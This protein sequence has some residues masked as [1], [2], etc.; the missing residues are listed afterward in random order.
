MRLSLIVAMAENRIIGRDGA[1]PWHISADLR[2]FK[3]VT[4]GAP[5]IMGRK[6]FQSIGRALPG[7]TNII[8]TRDH[9]FTGD[10]IEV[11]HDLQAALRKAAALCLVEGR[12]E[13]FVIGGAQIYELALE[14]AERIYL[15]E[16]HTSPP[17][18]TRFPLLDPDIWKETSREDHGPESEGGPAFSFLI[19]DKLR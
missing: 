19:L 15:T 17:G 13:V 6:T 10:G 8:I 2:Y 5:V 4:M 14:Q 1:M 9:D 7:R 11:V 3:Q 18:D 16:I 12:E